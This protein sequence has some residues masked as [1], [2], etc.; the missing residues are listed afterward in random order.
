MNRDLFPVQLW[1]GEQSVVERHAE[2]LLMSVLCVHG[3]CQTCSSC[4]SIKKKSHYSVQYMS[5]Q[6]DA[7]KIA[8][9]EA[10][11]NRPWF[12]R[13]ENDPFF[14][15]IHQADLIPSASSHMLLKLFEEPT[16]GY[17]FIML[18]QRI[19]LIIP[20][21]VSRA[22]VTRFDGEHARQWDNFIAMYTAPQQYNLVQWN[23][24]FERS[25]LS[26][27]STK[28]V[29]DLLMHAWLNRYKK[30]T[31]EKNALVYVDTHSIALL[32]KAA[33]KFPLPGSIKIFW[34]SL[35]LMM[36]LILKK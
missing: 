7:Y 3:G 28:M 21:L 29:L 18:A 25:A 4:M 13:D 23:D 8:E 36:K 24:I 10:V 2:Q 35:F 33:E 20:T 17:Y 12:V 22:V 31:L 15:I 26:E 9:V 1:V 16:C 30:H 27:Y 5:P 6:K 34:R 19:E 32:K 11:F 14:F